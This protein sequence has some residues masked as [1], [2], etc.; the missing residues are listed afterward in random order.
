MVLFYYCIYPFIAW[1]CMVMHMCVEGRRQLVK[2]DSLLL[3]YGSQG[4]NS[5]YQAWQKAPL[6]AESYCHPKCCLFK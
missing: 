2:L 3:T 5:G 6:P 4:S 1:L